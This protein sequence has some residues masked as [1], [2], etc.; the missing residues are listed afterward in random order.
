MKI[1][2]GTSLPGPIRQG[3][4]RGLKREREIGFSVLL[5]QARHG[6]LFAGSLARQGLINRQRDFSHGP[7]FLALQAFSS[8]APHGRS[9]AGWMEND[10]WFIESRPEI[11]LAFASGLFFAW[12]KKVLPESIR[13]NQNDIWRV[14]NRYGGVATSR[15][16][17]KWANQITPFEF[18]PNLDAQV[19]LAGTQNLAPAM[20]QP[21]G[22]CLHQH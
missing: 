14:K 19:Q 2:A 15:R 9:G 18:A 20:G 12:S 5:S 16:G 6:F 7:H 8:G 1:Y 4:R 21:Q 17:P 3:R 10:C 13:L 22:L 11:S